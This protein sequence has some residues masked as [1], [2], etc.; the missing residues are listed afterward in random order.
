MKANERYT[1]YWISCTFIPNHVMMKSNLFFKSLLSVAFTLTC[2]CNL[3][4]QFITTAVG[5]GSA[6]YSGDAGQATAA[7]L[8]NPRGI[9]FDAAGNL[10]ISDGSNHVIRKVT[11][12]GIITTIAGTGAA[13]FSGDGAAATAA[14]LDIPFS[15]A[16]DAAGNIYFTDYSQNVVRKIN[17]SGIISTIAGVGG[18]AGYSGVG[19]PAT[20]ALLSTPLGIA[21]D[22]TGNVFFS[23]SLNSVVQE[24]TTGGILVNVAGNGTAGYSGDGAAATAASLNQPTGL[25]RDASGNIYIAEFANSVV[26]KV[27]PT[28]II[29]TVAGIAGSSGFGGDGGPATNA[30]LTNPEGVIVD[31]AG[32][33]Y[34]A[35]RYNHA[36][37]RINTA[38]IISTV[39]GTGGSLGYS[40]DGG[41]AVSAA[42]NAPIDVKFDAAG[43][44][45]IDDSH[46]NVIRKVNEGIS[47]SSTAGTAICAGSAGT[48]NAAYFSSTATPYFQWLVNGSYVGTDT[49]VFTT[50]TLYNG[51][52]VSC[53]MRD[54]TATGAIIGTSN[55]ITVH[56][57]YT[58]IILLHCPDICQGDTIADLFYLAVRGHPNNY[59]ISWTPDG[60]AQGLPYVNGGNII[61]TVAGTSGAGYSGDGGA[62]TA[63]NMTFPSGIACDASGNVFIADADNHV[64][65]KINGSGVITTFAGTGAIGNSGDG[66]PATAAT[67]S[68]PFSL[69]TDGAG[70]LYVTDIDSN[71]IRK[72]NPYGIITLVAGNGSAGYSGDG[73]PATAAPMNVPIGIVADG[74]VGNIYFS[75]AVNH[76]V[77]K[78]SASGIISTVAGNGTAGYSGDGGPAT[79]ALLNNPTGITTDGFGNLYF[80][81][82]SNNVVR[83]IDA[84]G[85]ISTVTYTFTYSGG[86]GGA[87]SGALLNPEG[88]TVDSD[89]N[90]Y[91]A[92]RSNS[93]I[94]VIHAN[95]IMEN[96]GGNGNA[97]YS[98]D[99]G[100]PLSAMVLG[101]IDAKIDNFS[102]ALYIAEGSRVRKISALPPP[103][104]GTFDLPFHV[105]AS[106]A[107]GS[108]NGYFTISNPTCG[109][110][111]SPFTLNI[112]SL[113]AGTITGPA[114]VCSTAS[115]TLSDTAT[116]GIWGRTNTSASVSGGVVTGVLPGVD[117][118]TYSVTNSCG[119]A[120]AK[121]AITI[122]PLPN[123]GTIS[124]ISSVCLTAAI[125]LT[126]TVSGGTWTA[127]NAHA[128]VS[129]GGVVV[130][131]APGTDTVTYTVVNGCGIGT[132]TKIIT[133][134]PLP[135]AGIIS[136]AS[137]VCAPASITLSETAS[138]GTWSATNPHA[139]I[140]GT[141]VVSGSS[142]GVDTIIYTVTNSCG[143]AI[144]K[145][146]ITVNTLPL[147]GAISGASSLCPGAAITL[148]ETASGGSWSVGNAHAVVSSSGVLT[149]LTAGIDTITYTSTNVCGTVTATH[150]DTVNALPNA[151]AISGAP[152][153]CVSSSV[154]LTETASGG[155][156]S[157]TNPHA[158]IAGTGVVSGTSAGIDTIIYTF[159]NSCGI[160]VTSKVITINPL[161]LPG[162]I[163]G[164]TNLCAGATATLTE[165]VP[166]GAWSVSNT[167][168]ILSSGGILT[169]S[170]AG[171][172][173]VT[174]TVTNMC[175]A[176]TATYVD[177]INAL[178]NAGTILGA[179]S[180]CATANI[181]LTETATGGAWSASNSH[182]II[183]GIGVV[184]G[185]SVGV[186][187]VVYTYTN[188]CGTATATKMITIDPM[189]VV[190]V[191]AGATNVCVGASVSFTDSVSGGAWTAANGNA[192]ISST[193]VA[194]GINPGVDS[195]YYTVSNGCGNIHAT[196]ILM[197]DA[198]PFASSITGPNDVCVGS[199]I[200]LADAASGG[201]W[202]ATNGN[203]TLLG[204]VATGVNAGTDTIHYTVANGCGIA[205][206]A[207]YVQVNPLPVPV[208]TGIGGVLYTTTG[209]VTYQW[210]QNGSVIPGAISPTYIASANDSFSVIVTDAFGCSATSGIYGVSG[211]S[212]NT[213]NRNSDEIKI[214]PNPSQSLVKIESPIKIDVVLTSLDGKLLM[215]SKDAKELNIST[216]ADGNFMLI[217]YDNE[218]GLKL[219][220]QKLVKL[221]N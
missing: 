194:N 172:D 177:T 131:M 185:V 2:T 99:G 173:T 48:F 206:A 205:I 47:I 220:T 57:I 167:H 59:N 10:Y 190:S 155:T 60:Y 179:S 25:A 208:I 67:F 166:G 139:T 156:W 102:G 55:S 33:I 118:I 96:W 41:A 147:A 182:A 120:T 132:A 19:G 106:A 71:V 198:L 161:P 83:K 142:A 219:K 13:G 108:Y 196:K 176:A 80:V 141:G 87:S 61:S 209:Y 4:A 14:M 159:T 72:I 136:G 29:S 30:L 75:D 11:T 56:V 100:D 8:S 181:T 127:S 183:S 77:R 178:P 204:S 9:A 43:N 68:R 23:N 7:G 97:G 129:S 109:S 171:I 158:T 39:A 101:P 91:I 117:T 73:G 153:V 145:Q 135:D 37:R 52:V 88:I 197:V 3:Y 76:A 5:N 63:A 51:D 138:G 18:I 165:T 49:S 212:V 180:V 36:I 210:M 105:P 125:A 58:G 123:P 191:I 150:I 184:G 74:G 31:G 114:V 1:S 130:G 40:G 221:N 82:F 195:I 112:N 78:I 95:G 215:T 50:S 149:G 169:G 175:G 113:S 42:L 24:I 154:S 46:N 64:I 152:S 119:T 115:I 200:T 116:G 81:E 128:I 86:S 27:T 168:G 84:S 146:A 26:R 111:T 15:I 174:Y 6:S 65:R 162:S 186:D 199:S 20:A 151:G 218:T 21:V 35:D 164:S 69:A 89:G 92:D 98:G 157:A 170:T 122:N 143:T 85:I 17:T 207:T 104:F 54:G 126:D 124:G 192:F 140:A 107:P 189:P 148:T 103:F 44:L 160:A 110:V 201:G 94:R 34:I 216:L 134:N 32:N 22:G 214:Y 217:I 70:N 163:S 38:G 137:F 45:Y 203:A 188:N 28:G 66:G 187:T 202:S 53:V 133:V 193:G 211:L 93:V 16:L 12:T 90:L 121:K 62:A 144:A 79:A 213:I